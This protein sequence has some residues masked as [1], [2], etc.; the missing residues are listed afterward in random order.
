MAPRHPSSFVRFLTENGFARR[1]PVEYRSEFAI[2]YLD[3]SHLKLLA[4][5]F[6]PFVI[7]NSPAVSSFA[8]D[9]DVEI[10]IDK[11]GA[12]RGDVSGDFFV[13]VTGAKMPPATPALRARLRERKVALLDRDDMAAIEACAGDR[14]KLSRALIRAIVDD[15][16]RSALSPYRHSQPAL[17]ERFFGRD[18]TIRDALHSRREG[19]A[20]FVGCRRIGK[21]SLLRE[22][23]R[24]L[25]DAF[26]ERLKVA[27]IYG[28]RDEYKNP[29]NVL[30]DIVEQLFHGQPDAARLAADPD[31]PRKFPSIIR[32]L[33]ERGSRES[34]RLE[35]AVFIDEY[36][37]L[38]DEDARR[39]YGLL[40]TLRS[41]FHG[42]EHCHLFFAG[43]RRVIR[44]FSNAGSEL[45][46]CGAPIDVEGLTRLE[47]RGMIEKP[48][49]LLGLDIRDDMVS[50]IYQET[51]GRPELIQ[52][53]CGELIAAADETG[54][55]LSAADL[56]AKVVHTSTF[57]AKISSTFFSNAEPLEEL[58]CLLL[59]ARWET[60]GQPI[61]HFEFG[62]KEADDLLTQAKVELGVVE[63]DSLLENLRLLGAIENLTG[64]TRY[65]IAV[66]A[67]ADYILSRDVR[68][69]I[70]KALKR[71]S[72][73]SS[74]SVV[75]WT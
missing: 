59:V 38:L 50:L 55:L 35:V 63:I 58:L 9:L 57:R 41:A 56:T 65:R 2:H 62:L 44:E 52:L 54:D 19:V 20:T 36:D 25:H 49:R 43:F 69:L 15:L 51:K 71:A 31:L 46:N 18:D 39:G 48:L 42:R 13:L 30:K 33:P 11:L 14:D 67:F 66:P 5:P 12:V 73:P 68:Y 72:V 45:H 34:G 22:V 10:V 29:E 47:A 75:P 4:G 64:S 8:G 24:R 7:P 70:R 6:T 21:T 3:L 26:G 61:E 17:G 53:F 60:S 32:M 37:D 74:A 40:K 23:H 27:D 16:G 28:S 1:R